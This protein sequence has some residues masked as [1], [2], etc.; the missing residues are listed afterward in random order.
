MSIAHT[1]EYRG[2]KFEIAYEDSPENPRKIEDLYTTMVCWHK[3]YTLGDIQPTCSPDEFKV[4]LGHIRV[5]VEKHKSYKVLPLFLYDHSGITMNTRGFSC[6]LDS[7]KVGFIYMKL[8]KIKEVYNLPKRTTWKSVVNNP[9]YRSDKTAREILE[10]GFP[11]DEKIT[12]E[13]L[14]LR[15]M[16]H[17]V[18]TYDCYLTGNIFE[19]TIHWSEGY[20]TTS[21][22]IGIDYTIEEAKMEIDSYLKRKEKENGI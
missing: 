22:H 10:D 12:V 1:E 19:K 21:G 4:F 20:E 5:D 17:D 3:R 14:A 13:N 11:N 7:G 2:I 8:E 16:E 15:F 9:W 6:R 18:K